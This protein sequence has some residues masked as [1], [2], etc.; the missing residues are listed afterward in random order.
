MK[1]TWLL[2]FGLILGIFSA[3]EDTTPPEEATP[4]VQAPLFQKIPAATSGITHKSQ[5]HPR[6]IT[7]LLSG[8][9]GVAAGDIN[10]DGLPDLVFSGGFNNAKLYL[11]KGN[12]QFEDITASAGIVDSGPDM[13]HSEGINLVDVN[14]DGWLDLSL[15]HI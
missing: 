1:W 14:G 10:Q 11:N 4:T 8:G 6:D 12:F 3:C 9:G 5:T 13:A 15:I 7:G 2:S